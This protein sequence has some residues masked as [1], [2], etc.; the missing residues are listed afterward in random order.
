MKN[1]KGFTMVEL[2]VSFVIMSFLLGIGVVSYN[3]I[4]D[5]VAAN[6]YDTLEEELLLAGSDY[7]TNNRVEKPLSGYNAVQIDELVGNKYIETLKDRRGKVCDR[8]SDS[9]VYIYKTSEGYGYEACLV[10][11]DY[12]TEGT[13]C[14]GMAL[15]VINIS[16]EKEGGGSYNPLLSFANASWSN[17]DVIVTFSV[18]VPVTK[19]V[20]TDTNNSIKRTCNSSNGRSCSMSF[21]NTSAYKVEAY[22]GSNE[23]APDKGFNIKI[24]K[25][26]PVCEFVSGPSVALINQS[27]TSTYVLECTDNVGLKNNYNIDSSNFT[28]TTSNVILIQ[29]HVVTAITNGYR[30]TVTVSGNISGTT[31]LKLNA[32]V[33]TDKAGNG[34]S[35]TQSNNVEVDVN[36][37][38]ISYNL[39]SGTYDENKTVT[40]T[41]TDNRK[42]SSITYQ[43]YKD[44]VLVSSGNPPGASITNI[45]FDSNLDSDGTW[46]LNVTAIDE[47]GNT[48]NTSRNFIIDTVPVCTD[49]KQSSVEY[50]SRCTP[51]GDSKTGTSYTTCNLQWRY[52]KYMRCTCSISNSGCDATGQTNIKHSSN[53]VYANE[54][55]AKNACTNYYMTCQ[56][57][58]VVTAPWCETSSAYRK[59]VYKRTCE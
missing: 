1:K 29:N 25:V 14:D 45:S 47:A 43:L 18:N 21:S 51:V 19:F 4:I 56:P 7:F 27:L 9:K 20:V 42:I 46:K 57:T 59:V 16:A 17:K 6:Y 22:D 13:Y 36:A 32:G 8:S 44:E 26:K 41:V 3:F 35:S 38:Q 55:N 2:L 10:C 11:N 15:G 53:Y 40:V 5:M 50:V 28:L 49:W 24:D 30:Y 39:A 54:T 58:N 12:K 52:T 31:A 34:N 23:V 37:P 48:I 33:I